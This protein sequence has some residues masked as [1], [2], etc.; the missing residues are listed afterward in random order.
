[1][2]VLE[3]V[4]RLAH[5]IIPFI[6][7]ELW[8]KVSVAAGKRAESDETS[9]SVQPYPIADTSKIDEA[10]EAQVAELKA[11]IDAIRALR[12]EMSLAP[13]QRVPLNASG[14]QAVLSR[15][16]PYLAALARLSE[17]KV[18]DTLPDL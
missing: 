14:D 9:V 5:P 3:T 16:A 8:Q 17:V 15:N 10:A 6:T 12:G 11:Q 13:S 4:L 18:V 1:I 2:R 7:E